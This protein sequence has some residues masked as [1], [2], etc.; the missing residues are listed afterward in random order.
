VT[1][2][3]WPREEP[4]EERLLVVDPSA[5]AVRPPRD[6][7]AAGSG[8]GFGLDGTWEEG[9]VRELPRWLS[10]GDLVVVNDAATVPASF[11]ARVGVAERTGEHEGESV[12][13]GATVEL[14]LA[15]QASEESWLAVVFGAGDWR[16]RTEH[17]P[18]PARIAAQ[19][20]LT[21]GPDLV[22]TV[23]RLDPRSPRLL[24]VRFNQRGA[25]LWSALYRYGHPVQYAHVARPLEVWHAQTPFASRP[26]AVEM[27]SAGRPLTWSL[28]AALRARGVRLAAITHAAGLSSTGEPLLD[29]ALPLPERFDIPHATVQAVATA[30]AEGRR[31]LAV[32]TT[33]VRALEGCAKIHGGE[34]VAVEGTTDL[35][36]DARFR[37][38][39]ADGVLT[40]MHENGSSH[41]KLL[42]A[43]APEPLLEAAFAHA[44]ARGYLSH[45][46]GD[47]LL[48]WPS[49]R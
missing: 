33:V 12:G 45:E 36:I 5:S 34:L 4:L 3:A 39:V 19:D 26:W 32:G 17:R 44:E 15:A 27:P 14:R 1:P 41:R 38:R 18:P 24:V 7:S 11:F 16:T 31:V 49:S 42:A 30:R 48:V 6:K 22:A 29:A 35:R 8:Q 20:T 28:V 46:F 9:R 47:T 10:A 23:E 37:P 2:A 21:I 40:G 13:E 25:A 43:F